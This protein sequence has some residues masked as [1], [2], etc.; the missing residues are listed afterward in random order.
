VRVVVT[1][2][3]GRIGRTVT[4]GLAE[5]GHEVTG[6]DLVATDG[7]TRVDVTEIPAL[8]Q[9]FDGHDAVVHLAAFAGEGSF[10]TAMRTH[11]E[12]TYAVLEAMRLTGVG[13]IVYASSH[14]AVGFTPLP[15]TVGTDVRP[16]P[17][18]FYGVGKLAAEA[19]C[20][21]YV[22][23]FDM[24]AVCLRIGAFR[25]KPDSRNHLGSWL[26]PG[27]AIRLVEA[28]LTTPNPGFAVVYGVSANTRGWFDLEPGRRIGYHP[29]DDAEA[30]AEEI[31]AV[32]ESGADTFAS[33]YTGGPFCAVPD[34]FQEPPR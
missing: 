20:S 28:G 19:L 13:R 27:D 15:A 2:A 33:Q 25:H 11:A 10:A 29:E 31:L 32:P 5:H 6:L 17:D 4:T 3:A 26:S 18:T 9:L 12:M 22:D 14:H 7:V 8:V 34:Y 23:R 21:L 30:Y 1:G 16:R 24:D